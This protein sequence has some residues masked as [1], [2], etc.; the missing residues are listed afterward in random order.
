MQ[1]VVLAG[2]L[3]T[4][5]GD[6]SKN[7]PKSLIDIDGKPFLYYQLDF[8]K[9]A[10]ITDVVL[11][12]GHLGNQ[13]E[14]VFGDGRK[15]G[16]NIQYSVE[17]TLLGTA[18]AIKNAGHLLEDTFFTVYGDS[19]FQLNFKDILQYFQSRN[20][21]A[22]MTVLRNHDSYDRSNTAIE[23]ELVT[24]YDKR[25]TLGTM[26]Y[27]DYGLNLFRK[28]FLEYIPADKNTGLES[29]FTQLIEERQ[30]LAY[31]VKDRFY[32][33]GSVKGLHEFTEYIR[34]KK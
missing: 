2:G 27:V 7:R 23:G 1:A 10:G 4:R 32:E 31:E 18:G 11:C 19:Y 30:L 16:V 21:I 12:I 26:V 22:L 14:D 9:K 28:G 33:I 3:A 29:V 5:L 25:N 17:K 24:G 20:N 8:M 13:I 34:S 6:I 15:W